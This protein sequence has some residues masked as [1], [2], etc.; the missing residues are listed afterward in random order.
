M[1]ALLHS[2]YVGGYFWLWANGHHALGAGLS[3]GW[4]GGPWAHQLLLP[5]ARPGGVWRFLRVKRTSKDRLG[6]RNSPAP[7]PTC[8]SWRV[9]VPLG[10]TAG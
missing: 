5:R 10:V 2:G 8:P 9:T 4:G 1:G 3:G 7:G 6:E